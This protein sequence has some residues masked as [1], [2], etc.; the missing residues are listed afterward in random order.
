MT[1]ILKRV[2]L[3]SEGGRS[4]HSTKEPSTITTPPGKLEEVLQFVV[5]KA[6]GVAALNGCHQD[7][8]HQASSRHCAYY[9][10]SS[11]GQD[12]HSVAEGIC[13]CERSIQHEGISVKAPVQ[14]HY[15][16]CIIRIASHWLYQHQGNDK[17]GS[18][19]NVVNNLVFCNH[20]RKHVMAYM[21]HDQTVAEFLWHGY[22]SI[23]I[24]LAKP[25]SDWET[26]FE[27]NI[28]RELCNLMGIRK[29]R[30]SPHHAQTNG[31]VEWAH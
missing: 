1:Q 5:P 31:Q 27:S 4:W 21:T 2:G 15:C 11:G 22:I 17:A 7:V 29:V 24:A 18:T 9:M 6:H 13:N 23:F 28:I 3:Y 20:F 19:T 30:T 25:L 26:N 14:A 16:N 12:D 10:T 8:G